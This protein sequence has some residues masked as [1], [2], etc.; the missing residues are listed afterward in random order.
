MKNE[1]YYVRLH[2]FAFF[3]GSG[4]V[5]ETQLNPNPRDV[6]PFL[7]SSTTWSFFSNRNTHFKTLLHVVMKDARFSVR[8]KWSQQSVDWGSIDV[9]VTEFMAP[10]VS[11]AFP[12]R[13]EMIHLLP[14]VTATGGQVYW[15]C[16][17]ILNRYWDSSVMDHTMTPFEWTMNLTKSKKK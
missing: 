1:G 7:P 6:H 9:K 17:Y 4:M 10:I 11:E 5:L 3:S 15:R 2:L 12:V 13:Q 14:L 8:G 16:Q